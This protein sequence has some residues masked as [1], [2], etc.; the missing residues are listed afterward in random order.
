[1]LFDQ[2]L[3]GTFKYVITLDADSC[4]VRDNASKLVGMID[5][6]L[7]H[8]VLDDSNKKIKEGY[9]II[10]PSVRNHINDR[11][12]SAFP[13]I[14]GGQEGLIHYSSVVSDIYQDIFREGSYIGKGIYNIEI[15]HQVLRKQIPENRVLSH[16][17]LE[18]CYAKTAFT[19]A[20]NIMDD[21]P[22][23]V[24]SFAKREHRWIRGRLA[25]A[26]VDFLIQKP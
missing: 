5:H 12:G 21:F 7:N 14:V 22:G 17:L 11:N 4:L 2:S 6:P 10:Q 25:A 19:G 18:S 15:F 26:S 8:A 1:M 16:D 20:A 3:L 24:L 9:A 13:K 23:S